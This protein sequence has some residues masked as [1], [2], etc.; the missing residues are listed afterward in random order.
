MSPNAQVR[1]LDGQN[2]WDGHSMI[3]PYP[4]SQGSFQTPVAKSTKKETRVKYESNRNEGRQQQQ[5]IDQMI[6][7]R[8]KA[9]HS[10]KKDKV[11]P[12]KNSSCK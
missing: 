10:L 6:I 1:G 11:S 5:R 8:V 9:T 2:V 3:S 12:I 4:Y 7:N